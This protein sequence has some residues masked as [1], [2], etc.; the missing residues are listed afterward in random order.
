M[1][2]CSSCRLSEWSWLPPGTDGAEE[3]P[4]RP[5]II[6]PVKPSRDHSGQ[7]KQ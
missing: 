7:Q 6:Q 5:Q 4:A 3:L 1:A 2:G